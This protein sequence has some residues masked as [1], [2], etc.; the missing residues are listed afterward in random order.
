MGIRQGGEKKGKAEKGR[1][2][3]KEKRKQWNTKQTSITCQVILIPGWFTHRFGN[4][5]KE[6]MTELSV[7]FAKPS[8]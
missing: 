2:T 3:K 1:R 7:T 5:V 6:W 4:M 8:V